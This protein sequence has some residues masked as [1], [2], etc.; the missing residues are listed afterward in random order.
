MAGVRVMARSCSPSHS[1]KTVGHASIHLSFTYEAF[2]AIA[3]VALSAGGGVLTPGANAGIYINLDTGKTT[4]KND[5]RSEIHITDGG[6]EKPLILRKEQINRSL[7]QKFSYYE[8]QKNAWVRQAIKG[9]PAEEAVRASQGVG[10]P[11]SGGFDAGNL[12]GKMG[13]EKGQT[14]S[15]VIDVMGVRGYNDGDPTLYFND[16]TTG[17]YHP[18]EKHSGAANPGNNFV[19][20][21]TPRDHIQYQQIRKRIKGY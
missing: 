7:P 18:V 19:P 16:I 9:T 15:M 6:S 21:R 10:D 12:A 13:T 4:L 2:S 14:S 11:A 5:R 8:G 3:V 1:A 17:E 20:H